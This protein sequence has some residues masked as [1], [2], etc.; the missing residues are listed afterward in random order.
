MKKLQTI[1]R[2]YRTDRKFL[3]DVDNKRLF[4][5]EEEVP[6]LLA[7]GYRFLQQQTLS[8]AGNS[9]PCFLLYTRSSNVGIDRG[10]TL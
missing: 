5:K 3:M 7:K 6:S 10:E 8:R 2:D 1:H 9:W 4:V